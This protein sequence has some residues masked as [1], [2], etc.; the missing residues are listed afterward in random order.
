MKPAIKELMDDHQIILRMLRALNG[1][2]LCVGEGK[3]VAVADLD[4]AL[5]FIKTFADYCHHGKEED[6]LFPAMGKVGFPSQGGPIGVML[7]EHE[8][9]RALVK[10]LSAA[11][12]RVRAGEAAALK[13]VACAASGYS[14]LL[15]EHIGKE[16]NILYPMAMEA[17]PEARW[18]V[19]K[20]EFDRVEEE[21]MGPKHRA[22]Y[23]ALV[24]RLVIA[25]PAPEL[26][27]P[28]G[29]MCH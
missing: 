27:R 29:G 6:L 26:A 15:S 28:S 13:N 12:E 5:D 23:V 25:Y 18:T 7:M 8:Q 19:L 2:C 21:R 11:L 24:D 3:K 16:D 14:S 1:M 9:G 10:S 17:L 20:R 4:A 22:K